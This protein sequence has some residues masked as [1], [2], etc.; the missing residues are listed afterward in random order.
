MLYQLHLV[1]KGVR[2]HT[3]SGDTQIAQVV[4]NPT[5]KWSRPRLNW[6]CS[7]SQL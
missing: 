6:K 7:N 2:T 3:F 5:T 4:V 1:I